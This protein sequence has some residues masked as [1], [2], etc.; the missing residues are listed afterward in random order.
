N[1]NGPVNLSVGGLPPGANATISP[2]PV[3]GSAT[4]SVSTAANTPA[5]TSA[6]TVSASATGV[7]VAPVGVSLTV[8]TPAPPPPSISNFFPAA[9]PVGTQVS[10]FG[11][12]FVNV[13]SVRFGAADAAFGVISP[14]QITATVPPGATTG[15]ITL[16]TSSGSAQSPA[17]FNVLAPK[18]KDTKDVKDKEVKERESKRIKEVPEGG[19]GGFGG[20][21]GLG[22]LR[23]VPGVEP[24]SGSA[25]D[26]SAQGR[27]FINPEE[28]PE[29]GRRALNS[30]PRLPG[31]GE[32]G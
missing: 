25:E 27:S 32:Q 16:I 5:G 17:P 13:A 31:E 22:G 1:F 26:L 11:A 8:E 21:G 12:A 29:V 6:I 20:F 24:G 14:N 23:G 4:L 15:P 10:V 2:N 3:N 28:R 30:T 9:G 19:R 18:G 7:S